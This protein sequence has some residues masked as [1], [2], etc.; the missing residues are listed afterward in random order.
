MNSLT[1]ALK[2][3]T[4]KIVEKANGI[5]IEYIRH[6]QEKNKTLDEELASLRNEAAAWNRR[7]EEDG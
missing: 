3:N 1:E 5:Y 7:T 2:R 6:L 4:T